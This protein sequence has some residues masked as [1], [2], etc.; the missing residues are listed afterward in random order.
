M[1][2]AAGT[3]NVRFSWIAVGNRVDTARARA[4]PSEVLSPDFDTRL[5]NVMFN[6]GDRENSGAPM[7]WDGTKLRFDRAP[8]PARP[9]KVEIKP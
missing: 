9:A 4:L 8:E 1:A 2:V 6:E 5:K 7:W 3:A